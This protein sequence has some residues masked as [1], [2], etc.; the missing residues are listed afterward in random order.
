[1]SSPASS[2]CSESFA[3]WLVKEKA[4]LALDGDMPALRNICE[5]EDEVRAWTKAADD[6]VRW[7]SE[8]RQ[9]VNPL[10]AAFTAAGL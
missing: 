8:R 4:R 5:N 3:L 1:M 7:E 10:E 2:T 9:C 6:Q